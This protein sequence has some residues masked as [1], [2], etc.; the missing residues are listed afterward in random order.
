MEIPSER[1][2]GK[3]L[4]NHP[5]RKGADMRHKF[6]DHAELRTE[7]VDNLR[8]GG[9]EIEK[10]YRDR[11]ITWMPNDHMRVELTYDAIVYECEGETCI[12]FITFFEYDVDMLNILSK[13]GK[14]MALELSRDKL[15]QA[16]FDDEKE[17]FSDI[18]FSIFVNIG[19]WHLHD[20]DDGKK[21]TE[22]AYV[23][24]K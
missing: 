23:S 8:H 6:Y 24:V 12:D 21:R 4:G 22:V 11:V 19:V 1:E 13:I 18:Y 17:M 10:Q 15:D 9:W 2:S 5:D 14:S 7:I 16:L 3:P 20:C